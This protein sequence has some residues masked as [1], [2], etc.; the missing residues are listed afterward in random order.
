MSESQYRIALLSTGWFHGISLPVKE[1]EVDLS[2]Y[3]DY[4]DAYQ[5]IGRFL[6]DVYIHKRIHSALGYASP[7]HF[8]MLYHQGATVH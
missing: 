5:Q 4:H 2:E 3:F 1:E 8:E 7:A 6:D